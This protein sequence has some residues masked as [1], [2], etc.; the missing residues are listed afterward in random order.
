MRN[1][2]TVF[3]RQ[4]NLVL[5]ALLGSVGVAL[6]V[7]ANGASA[8][9]VSNSQ[10]L[11]KALTDH[12]DLG[13]H[14]GE[15]LDLDL[16]ANITYKTG[17]GPFHY[18]STAATGNL[19]IRGD[20]LGPNCMI[21][22]FDPEATVLDGQGATQVLNLSSKNGYIDVEELTIYRGESSVDFGAGLSVNHDPSVLPLGAGS[23]RIHH[24]LISG[25][26]SATEY[27]GVY[28][29]SGGYLQLSS[30]LILG[31]SADNL[32]GAGY[33]RG[34]THMLVVSN[35]ITQN[36]TT[37]VGGWGGLEVAQGTLDAQLSNNIF[38]NNTLYGAY[39]DTI[40]IDLDNN[41]YGVLGGSAPQTNFNPLINKNPR[42]VN[43]AGGDFHLAGNSPALGFS[44]APQRGNAVSDLEDHT[45]PLGG[46]IDV[47]AYE[48]TI[49]IDGFEP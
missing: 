4:R 29:V 17:N 22:G 15:D 38:W 35:T 10:D 14:A 49:F 37:H 46:N 41:D 6:L 23:I 19:S 33:V 31:N 5:R 24:N 28:A 20:F 42:F 25:N 7:L 11:Q 21:H 13:A 44:T 27:G 32:G 34:G 36:T 3:R 8:L 12:S 2:N 30:N 26:H 1:L 45:Y 43:A 39:L 9:C 18:L 47:G 48:E 40:N 16:V